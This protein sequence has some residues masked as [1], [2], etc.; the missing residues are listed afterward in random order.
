[1]YRRL[2]IDTTKHNLD[3]CR[4]N[5]P[6]VAVPCGRLAGMSDNNASMANAMLMICGFLSGGIIIYPEFVSRDGILRM[7][8]TWQRVRDSPEVL[9]RVPDGH[10]IL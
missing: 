6:C 8:R 1:M 3:G 10:S 7:V 2:F 9:H 5:V 4:E